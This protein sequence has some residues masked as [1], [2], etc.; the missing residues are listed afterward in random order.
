MIPALQTF[1]GDPDDIDGL[2]SSI[3]EQKQSIFVADPRG[4]RCSPHEER[5]ATAMSEA[6][7][8]TGVAGQ[9]S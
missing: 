9:R 1:I 3:E 2:T 6:T 4:G 5:T 7:P 8:G